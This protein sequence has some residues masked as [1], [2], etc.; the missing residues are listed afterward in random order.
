M[1][2]TTFP[3]LSHGAAAQFAHQL[4]HEAPAGDEP[5]AGTVHPLELLLSCRVDPGHVC[6]IDPRRLGA[7]VRDGA[8]ARVELVDPRGRE[9]AFELQHDTTAG[10]QRGDSEHLSLRREAERGPCRGAARQVL[11]VKAL[12]D[13]ALRERP[14]RR[15][16]QVPTPRVPA[17]WQGAQGLALRECR[18]PDAACRMPDGKAGRLR[19]ECFGAP[20]G[21]FGA[22]G[23]LDA[24]CLCQIPRTSNPSTRPS[25]RP[26]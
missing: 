20:R 8:P 24:A 9:P 14:W 1:N 10:A 23:M 26:S 15:E 7:G 16:P 5:H 22:G 21:A 2:M 6:E 18:M 19:A 4:A 11:S 13:Q 25:A 17:D 12:R 3:A